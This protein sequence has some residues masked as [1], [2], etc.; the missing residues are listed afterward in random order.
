MKIFWN[1]F[2]GHTT[3]SIQVVLL[4]L[5]LTAFALPYLPAT[6]NDFLQPDQPRRLQSLGPRFELP[7][8]NYRVIEV[9]GNPYQLPEGSTEWLPLNEGDFLTPHTRIATLD[10]D[11]VVIEVVGISY[12]RLNEA[13]EITVR[14]LSRKQITR[15]AEDG[16]VRTQQEKSQNEINLEMYQGELDQTLRHHEDQEINY[17]VETPQA[18]L[19]IRGTSFTA[20]VDAD[21]TESEVLDG[22]VEFIPEQGLGRELGPGL[23]SSVKTG[24]T[25][26]SEPEML[27]AERQKEMEETRRQAQEALLLEPELDPRRAGGSRFREIDTGVFQ[28]SQDHHL[29]QEIEV[30][31]EARALEPDQEIARVK[32]WR[33]G[34]TLPIE[35][36]ENWSFNV[37]IDTL[38]VGQADTIPLQMVAED[39]TGTRSDTKNLFIQ[40]QHPDPE[41]VLPVDYSSGT[42]P[43]ELKQL[44]QRSVT[45]VEFPYQLYLDDLSATDVITVR[46]SASSD[47]PI[48]GVA[49]SLNRGITWSEAEGDS[50]WKF[51][52]PF[53]EDEEFIFSP[54][55]VAW[56]ANAEIGEAEVLPTFQVEEISHN[57]QIESLMETY[58]RSFYIR[59][60]RTSLDLHAGNFDWLLN[61]PGSLTETTLQQLYKKILEFG[62]NIQ[63]FT[64]VD[65]RIVTHEEAQVSLELQIFGRHSPTDR[66]FTMFASPVDFS[67]VR[68]PGGNYQLNELQ[69][70]PSKN[71]I[72]NS[73]P[74]QAT[75]PDGIS[76]AELDTTAPEKGEL[77]V[78]QQYDS[79]VV[80]INETQATGGVFKLE[81]EEVS[82]AFPV[83]SPGSLVYQQAELLERNRLY[84]F[85]LEDRTGRERIGLLRPT[86][87][88]DEKVSLELLLYED[89]LDLL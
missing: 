57:E 79:W 16:L 62:E 63:I 72:Y 28:V 1:K 65:Q 5:L 66:W 19:G 9:R 75:D 47:S 36:V 32:A 74:I 82:E 49:Y 64:S 35:G 73:E 30:E 70:F 44:G 8:L 18:T 17:E 43:V 14:E 52:I 54:R 38:P 33:A 67:W 26:I 13:S 69:N 56:N 45:G 40:T 86:K 71:Y 88:N 55:V 7:P 60:P 80:S 21:G 10:D 58:L 11:L 46:G 81:T 50:Q 27:P 77:Q 22:R 76:L 48:E 12:L 37:Q 20:R 41:D 84:A 42:V 34:D 61:N 51:E 87:T 39:D 6:A 29:P 4:L 85:A 31:G 53:S 68:M 2:P 24:D 83:P 23:K 78:D 89:L 15:D 59:D 3:C 25:D